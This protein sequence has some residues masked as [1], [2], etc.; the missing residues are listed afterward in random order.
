MEITILGGGVAG[1]ALAGAV[2]DRGHQPRVIDPSLGDPGTKLPAGMVNPAMG[3]RA[4]PGW[5]GE[6]CWQALRMRV[7]G[8]AR[9]RGVEPPI[10]EGGILRPAFTDEREAL[11]HESL[12]KYDWSDEQMTWLSPK[13]VGRRYPHL[14]PAK[15]AL[16]VRQGYAIHVREYLSLYRGWLREQGVDFRTEAASYDWSP[17][18]DTITVHLEGGER[19]RTSQLIIAAGASSRTFPGWETLPMNL[20]KGEMVHYRSPDPLPWST[21]IAG[22]GF[23]VRRG[24]RELVAGS[25]YNHNAEDTAPTIGARNRIDTKLK[26]LLP[27]LIDNLEW[28]DQWAGFRVTTPDRL[29]VAGLHP[30]WPALGIFSGLN[31]RG[32]LFS[33]RISNL[34]AGHLLDGNPL[35]EE[36]RPDRFFD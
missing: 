1:L 14:P 18:Q 15:G 34:L 9:W 13:E 27:G 16:L 32:L 4:K 6:A 8:L 22:R 12:E 24:A 23:V 35:P 10:Q 25:N 20:V 21:T 11:Y 36:I 7:D 33:E 26:E 2:A 17:D 29:P 28:I 5:Q 19:F 3:R 31:S 30:S